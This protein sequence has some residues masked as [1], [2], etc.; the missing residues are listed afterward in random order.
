VDKDV[1]NKSLQP[2]WSYQL[3]ELS[4]LR[5]NYAYSDRD[6]DALPT[7]FTD[8]ITDTWQ[9]V[10]LQQLTER[11]G[12]NLSYSKSDLDIPDIGLV[13]LPG[14]ELNTST[15]SLFVGINVRLSQLWDL[16]LQVGKRN[17]REKI[18]YVPI[19]GKPVVINRTK[20]ALYTVLLKRKSETMTGELS[21]I[22]K[23]SPSG[24]GQLDVKDEIKLK[25]NK[26]MST[27][28]S[29]S[30]Q[31]GYLESESSSSLET[32][33]RRYGWFSTTL[34]YKLGKNFL[35]NA[36]Y[37]IGRQKKNGISETAESNNIQLG[38]SYKMPQRL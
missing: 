31:L 16:D 28:L 9:L 15:D 34:D 36:G 38:L 6:Y 19:A 27:R 24:D 13:G 8:Y 4:R 7:E 1:I 32:T 21:A 25:L 23:L 18:T 17:T 33:R 30:L 3:S 29:L 35:L 5:L 22:R 26:S 2:F 10:F 14:V 20:G 11:T 12:V 37:R